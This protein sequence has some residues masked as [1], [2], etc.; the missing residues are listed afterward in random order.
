MRRGRR[1]RFKRVGR[2]STGSRIRGQAAGV[3]ALREVRRL[4]RAI[5][6]KYLRDVGVTAQIPIAGAAIVDGFGPY[7]AQGDGASTREGNEITVKSIAMKFNVKLTALEA[8]G[9]T[10][11]LMIVYDRD[12]EG[13]DAVVTDMLFADNLLSSYKNVGSNKGRFQF[14]ADRIIT[15]DSVQGEWNDKFWLKKDLNIEY[16]LGNAGTVAD[17]AKGNFLVVGMSK[18]NAA[19]INIDFSFKFMYTDN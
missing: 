8:D 15:F 13:A 16:G 6:V 5:E 11:R 3:K 1:R 12:P 7:M 14:L 18:G 4:Q 17:L 19:A 2:K 10:V 9:T